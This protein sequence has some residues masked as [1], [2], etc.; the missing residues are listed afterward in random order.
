VKLELVLIGHRLG[1]FILKKVSCSPL[2]QDYISSIDNNQALISAY[3]RRHQEQPNTLLDALRTLIMIGD[4]YLDNENRP[5]WASLVKSCLEPSKRCTPETFSEDALSGLKHIDEIFEQI[6]IQSQ[7]F[8]V[9]GKSSAPRR[10]LPSKSRM[11]YKNCVCDGN[12][13]VRM[14][15]TAQEDEDVLKGNQNSSGCIFSLDSVFHHPLRS[16]TSGEWRETTKPLELEEINTTLTISETMCVELEGTEAARGASDPSQKNLAIDETL[17]AVSDQPVQEVQTTYDH[18]KEDPPL[19]AN[20]GGGSGV[21]ITKSLRE[22]IQNGP[23]NSSSVHAI[24]ID[25]KPTG[26]RGAYATSKKT[27]DTLD[28]EYGPPYEPSHSDASSSIAHQSCDSD[29][30]PSSS[31]RGST[32]ASNETP[33]QRGNYLGHCPYVSLCQLPVRILF[34]AKVQ[35]NG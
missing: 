29:E 33:H 23:A 8:Q 32:L 24:K 12:V 31:S 11:K 16:I 2:L 14:W 35:W 20:R 15:T 6:C 30:G 27:H 25:H 28:S 13:V 18:T 1:A 17:Q 9:S 21:E 4:P 22:H 19:V 26:K 34:F 3:R 10:L 5:Q 7:F